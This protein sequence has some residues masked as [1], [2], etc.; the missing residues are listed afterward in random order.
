LASNTALDATRWTLDEITVGLQ[1]LRNAA[2]NMSYADIANAIT[3]ARIARGTPPAAANLSRSTVYDCFKHGRS[4]LNARLVSEIVTILTDDPAVGD[5]YRRRCL[6]AQRSG[7]GLSTIEVAAET[8][9]PAEDAHPKYKVVSADGRTE[10]LA[11][12]AVV[13][14]A[15]RA[16]NRA[17]TAGSPGPNG[18]MKPANP[19]FTAIM[20]LVGIAANIVPHAVLHTVF[21]DYFPLFADMLGTAIVALLLGPAWAVLTALLSASMLALASGSVMPLLFAPVAL[22]GA[23]IWG[24]GVWRFKMAVTL[25]R[26]ITLNAAVGTACTLTALA[27]IAVVLG[28]DTQMSVAENMTSAVMAFGVSRL[29]AVFVTNWTMSLADKMLAGLIALFLA[30]TSLRKYANPNLMQVVVSHND[31]ASSQYD[32]H[33]AFWR[34]CLAAFLERKPLVDAR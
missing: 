29:I 13:S 6:A 1:E 9:V 32:N 16:N 31:S 30:G 12:T 17:A 8:Q 3:R 19:R 23:L 21:G 27:V 26:F 25:P 34:P 5:L 28:G 4:R 20:L 7:E 2:D 18:R 15:A 14:T 22:I 11:S 10:K 33:I 24:F